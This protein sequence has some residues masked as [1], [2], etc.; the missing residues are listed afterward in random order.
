[1]IRN[2]TLQNEIL[3]LVWDGKTSDGAEA[4][5]GLYYVSY[6]VNGQVSYQK[7]I[8]NNVKNKIMRL[9]IVSL[10]FLGL[11]SCGEKNGEFKNCE[12]FGEGENLCTIKYYKDGNVLWSKIFENGKLTRMNKYE[13]IDENTKKEQYKRKKYDQSGVLE[14]EFRLEGDTIEYTMSLLEEGGREERYK[15]LKRKDVK[16]LVKEYNKD[17]VFNSKK[18]SGLRGDNRKWVDFPEEIKKETVI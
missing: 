11:I 15:Y 16:E 10:F 6:R 17:N 18:R 5:A 9:L 2:H 7:L 13:K 12:D 1:M 4:N 14:Y 8:K 3:K